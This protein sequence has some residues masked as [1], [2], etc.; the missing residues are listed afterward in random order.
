V[1]TYTLPYLEI[2]R[3]ILP[4]E[5]KIILVTMEQE[6]SA[7][8]GADL[9]ELNQR[10]QLR[11]MQVV[12]F[13]YKRFGLAKLLASLK[14]TGRLFWLVLQERISVIHAFGTPAGATGYLLGK[15]TGRPLVIDSY[16]PHAES[17][18]ENKTW[19]PSGPAY[20]ILN[21]LEKLQTLYASSFIATS[22]GMK[23][24]AEERFKTTLKD[25]HVKPA[26]VDLSIFQPTVKNS[27]LLEELGLRHKIVCVYAGKLGGIYLRE[28]VFDFIRQ[29]Y[30]HWG[31]HFRFLMLTNASKE[32]VR[33]E[34]KRTGVPSE[35]VIQKFVQHSEVPKYMSLADFAL[36]PVKPVPTKRYCTSIK[37]GEY[38]ATGLP[39]V[40]TKDISDDSEIIEKNGIGYQLKD[41][42]ET[43][44]QNA[45]KKIEDLLQGN[46]DELQH[47]IRR[48][49]ERYRSYTIATDIYT[50]IYT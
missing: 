22:S 20:K 10:L 44:Y 31:E 17:M 39:V 29:C 28:E 1:Q 18:V 19:N 2:I 14:E 32:E 23:Q 50:K 26:C 43:E 30:L 6:K 4:R 49:A 9:A 48:L 33:K 15:F 45:I 40:I 16:E 12:A 46:R 41:L 21:K 11:N 25:F 27:T 24:Y 34:L 3:D 13:P 7:L 5:Y 42:T 36:N 47:K 8:S 38:W 37:D 35:V